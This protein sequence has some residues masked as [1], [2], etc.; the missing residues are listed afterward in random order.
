VIRLAYLFD[1]KPRLIKLFF[2]IT[3]SL[4]CFLYFIERSRWR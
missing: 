1:C 2:S 4:H 3:C